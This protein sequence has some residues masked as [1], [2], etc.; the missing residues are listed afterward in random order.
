M[1]NPIDLVICGFDNSDQSRVAARWAA[2]WCDRL[3]CQLRLMAVTG[4]VGTASR[5]AGRG[6]LTPAEQQGPRTAEALAALRAELAQVHPQLSIDSAVLRGLP[7]DQLLEAS[8]AGAL[9]VIGTRGLSPALSG[10]LGGVAEDVLSNASGPI[11]VVPSTL[12][13][14]TEHVVTL[15]IDPE[16]PSLAALRFALDIAERLRVGLR[17]VAAVEAGESAERAGLQLDDVVASVTDTHAELPIDQQVIRGR[18]HEVLARAAAGTELLVVG[19]R[20]RGGLA[21]RL[22]G[23]TSRR[24]VREARVATAVVRQPRK[25]RQPPG[26]AAT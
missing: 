12:A 4:T 25:V 7:A 3:G 1:T 15:G 24:V 26:T 19:S 16:G 13:Q 6:R 22:L 8:R 5:D 10:L 9:V 20:G 21:G 14:P 2:D 18:P 17:V 11:V 23:S